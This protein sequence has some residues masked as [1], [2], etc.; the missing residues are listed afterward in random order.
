MFLQGVGAKCCNAFER[1]PQWVP[2]MRKASYFPEQLSCDHVLFNLI[3][4]RLVAA[5]NGREISYSSDAFIFF[6][7]TI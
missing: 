3:A 7:H 6:P 4:G 2:E 1:C 5:L